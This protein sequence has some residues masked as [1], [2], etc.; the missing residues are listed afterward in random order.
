MSTDTHGW[1]DAGDRLL[2]RSI[3]GTDEWD[4]AAEMIG[5]WTVM[6]GFEPGHIRSIEL[7]VGAG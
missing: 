4:V 5:N 2:A 7:S 1:T 3:F 6:Q